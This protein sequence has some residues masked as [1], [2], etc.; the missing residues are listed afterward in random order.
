MTPLTRVAVAVTS[1]FIPKRGGKGPYKVT[2]NELRRILADR[3]EGVRLS[4]FETALVSRLLEMRRNGEF[5]TVA[6]LLTALDD[7]D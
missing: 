7:D 4:D 6:G 5:I 3:K 1:V 2:M